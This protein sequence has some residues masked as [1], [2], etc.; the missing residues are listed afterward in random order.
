MT[1]E[2]SFAKCLHVGYELIQGHQNRKLLEH[3]DE[4][5]GAVVGISSGCSAA[6]SHC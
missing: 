6:K 5:G 2:K 1:T 3:Q 4:Y